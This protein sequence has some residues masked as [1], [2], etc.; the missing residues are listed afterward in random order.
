MR[1]PCYQWKWMI[2]RDPSWTIYHPRIMVM[3]MLI[4]VLMMILLMTIRWRP[5]LLIRHSSLS[6]SFR[7]CKHYNTKDR[8]VPHYSSNSSIMRT[9]RMT[10]C[11]NSHHR[12]NVVQFHQSMYRHIQIPS[13]QHTYQQWQQINQL[14]FQWILQTQLNR[15]EARSTL[16]QVD[17]CRVAASLSRSSFCGGDLNMHLILIRMK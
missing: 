15:K 12:C 3:I 8:V 16:P 13:N 10:K 5:I 11:C 2:Y 4:A 6:L 14:I 9:M 1:V 7:R 17:L